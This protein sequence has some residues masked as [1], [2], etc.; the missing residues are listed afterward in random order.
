MRCSHWP[1]CR[2]QNRTARHAVLEN[3]IK[4]TL[5]VC[6][7]CRTCVTAD[8]NLTYIYYTLHVRVLNID[9]AGFT[10]RAVVDPAVMYLA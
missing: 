8:P 3:R 6:V 7:R 5:N 10:M 1:V 2:R 9:C 4:R